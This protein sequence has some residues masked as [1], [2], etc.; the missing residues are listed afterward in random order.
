MTL[1]VDIRGNQIEVGSAVYY[2]LSGGIA[3][4]TIVAITPGIEHASLSYLWAEPPVVRIQCD[5]EW[6]HKASHAGIS[7]CTIRAKHTRDK[8]KF[9]CEYIVDKILVDL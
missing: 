2:N 3:R 6:L 4:G 8:W 1:L 9:P 7:T 5:P